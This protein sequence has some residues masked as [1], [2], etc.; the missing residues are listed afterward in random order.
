MI[1]KL[2]FSITTILVLVM[3]LIVCIVIA[4]LLER[5]Y[6]GSAA[7]ILVYNSWWFEILWIWFSVALLMNLIHF[8][9]WQRKKWDVVLFPFAF[10]I[11]LLGAILTRH[12]ASQGFLSLREGE[13]SNQFF[14]SRSYLKIGVSNGPDSVTNEYELWLSP[15]GKPWSRKL[16]LG[17]TPLFIRINHYIP[18]AENPETAEALDVTIETGAYR[19]TISLFDGKGI[20]DKPKVIQCDGVKVELRLGAKSF[21]L[22]FSLRLVDFRIERNENS[23]EPSQFRSDVVIEDPERNIEKPYSV[24]MNHIL[25]Y[26]GYRVYQYSFDEDEKGTIF[27]VSRDP[28]TTVTYAGFFLIIAVIGL[29]FFYPKSRIRELETGI[30]KSVGS[31]S[32]VILL[33][34]L[35]IM[36]LGSS[37]FH[38]QIEKLYYSVRIFER[39]GKWFVVVVGIFLLMSAMRFW[40]KNR[41]EKLF[42]ILE[43]LFQLAVWFGFLG[44]T[45]GLGIRWYLS[46]HAPLSNKYESMV[47][48]AWASLLAG[49]ILARHSRLSMICGSLLSGIVLLM[50]HTPSVDPTISPLAPVLKS[51]W[52]ILHV[53]IAIVSYGFFAVGTAMAFCNL[54]ALAFPVSGKENS[55][56]RRV[57]IW[58]KITEQALWIGIFLLAVGCILG[59]IWA[60]ETWGRYWGWDPKEAWTLIVILSY[61]MLLH[62]RFVL[63]SHWTYWLNVWA[64][65]AFWS[66]LMTYFG[67][68][69]F[70]S[71][72]HTYAG[73]RQAQFPFMVFWILG[74]WITLSFLAYRNRKRIL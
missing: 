53:S 19:R 35:G 10:L 18:N 25:R 67:V 4:T 74:I 11:I 21:R 3:V 9:L 48:A 8:K 27:L 49:I 12:F 7:R 22:P 17:K 38:V 58:S 64:L 63:R 55:F 37:P 73:E 61:A 62:L 13:S 1:R 31:F 50:A 70:F 33:C 47:F 36:C 24:Y 65:F 16:K 44:F 69:R 57:S 5:T 6:G 68:N 54:S 15:L 32:S 71:G 42:P 56:L 51:K 52:L 34:L 26:R 66:L 45:I 59:A 39:L 60:N 28:G 20:E 30:R 40:S 72:M 29:S 46:G 14:S 23:N 41:F 43:K 2:F